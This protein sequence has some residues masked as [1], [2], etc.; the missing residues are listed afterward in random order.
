M[1]LK[2]LLGAIRTI[3]IGA[4]PYVKDERLAMALSIVLGLLKAAEKIAG[5]QKPEKLPTYEEGLAEFLAAQKA[6]ESL[7][8]EDP[9]G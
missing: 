7:V 6:G 4:A 1:T 3:I 8:G 5:G 2:M 9:A